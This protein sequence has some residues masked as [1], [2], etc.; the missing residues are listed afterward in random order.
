M[1]EEAKRELLYYDWMVV[2]T[3]KRILCP[4]IIFYW[5][6]IEWRIWI[7][8]CDPEGEPSIWQKQVKKLEREKADLKEHA[9]FLLRNN[10]WKDENFMDHVKNISCR[11]ITEVTTSTGFLF[12]VKHRKWE[13][14]SSSKESEAAFVSSV[15]ANG[16]LEVL[17]KTFL[18]ENTCVRVAKSTIRPVP[19]KELRSFKVYYEDGRLGFEKVSSKMLKEAFNIKNNGKRD[20]I[21]S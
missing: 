19:K 20:F 13:Y 21:F 15:I 9:S 14:F 12:R 5:Q 3:G 11:G 4:P 6:L 16:S 2:P 8:V 18:P 10:I 17:V 7:F 1:S